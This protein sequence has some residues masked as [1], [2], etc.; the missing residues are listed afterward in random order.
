MKSRKKWIITLLV[1]ILFAGVIW[2]GIGFF[3]RR[4]AKSR[5][6]SAIGIKDRPEIYGFYSGVWTDWLK[7][8]DGYEIMHVYTKEQSGLTIK[9]IIPES[10]IW[11]YPEIEITELSRQLHIHINTQAILN[12]SVGGAQCN[13]WFFADH[14]QKDIPFDKKDFYL[15]YYDESSDMIHIYRGHHFYAP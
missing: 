15:G 7:Y 8:T 1:L 14:R 12:E 9:D 4:E 6:L 10:W 3:Q 11:E 5:M 2:F 13:A